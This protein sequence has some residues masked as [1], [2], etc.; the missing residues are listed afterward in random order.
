MKKTIISILLVLCVGMVKAQ[1]QF[2]LSNILSQSSTISTLPTDIKIV[3][4][5]GYASNYQGGEGIEKSFDGD[6]STQYHSSWGATTFP[7]T[8]RYDFSGEE[9][10]DYLT[11]C[12]R[13]SG[14]NG[15][16]KEFEIWYTTENT[17]RTKFGEFDFNGSSSDNRINFSTPLINPVSIEFVVKSGHANFASCAEMEFYSV[18]SEND[19]SDIFADNLMTTLKSGVTLAQINQISNSFIRDVATSIYS[20]TY[21][22]DYRLADFRSY[23]DLESMNTQLMVS[24]YNKYENPTGIYFSKGKHIIVA[25]NIENGKPVSLVIPDY[26]YT[27]GGGSLKVRSFPLHNGMNIIDVTDWDGLGYI[28]YFSATPELCDPVHIH[29]MKGHIHGYFDITKHTNADWNNLLKNATRY[30]VMDAVGRRCH[31]AYP[32]ESYKAFAWGQGVE[33]VNG[34]DT[35]VINQQRMLG[36][37]KYHKMPDNRLLVRVN[38]HY[39]MYKDGD[40]ASFEIGTMNEVSSPTAIF[41]SNWGITHEIGHVHQFKFN[42]WHGMGEVSVNIPNVIFKDQFLAALPNTGHYN[43]DNYDNAYD[44]IVATGTAFLAYPGNDLIDHNFGRLIPFAQLYHYFAEVGNYD[45]YPDINEA[46]RN[47]T[48]DISGWGVADYELNFIKKACEVTQLNLIPFFEKWGFLYYT[49]NGRS[50]FE[51]GDYGGNRTYT[52]PKASVDTLKSYI[53]SKGY[54]EP[55]TDITLVKPNGGRISR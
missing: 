7:I 4:S 3:P 23:L 53:L 55:E 12:P 28:S 47:T 39:F 54:P 27:E 45:F 5:G 50:D 32:V 25:E 31:I 20:G 19:F 14:S 34:Y 41:S 13:R 49:D 1:E 37:E 44:A 40:G 26:K 15:N 21:T 46:L 11:Y 24:A 6:Y 22:Y 17:E 42:N 43:P 48:D 30:P 9:R 35:I 29:F 38:Y 8:L 10:I 18:N 52:L 16:F 51:V 2:F 36:W 33:L